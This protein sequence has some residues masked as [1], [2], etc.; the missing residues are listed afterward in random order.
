MK[1]K[2]INSPLSDDPLRFGFKMIFK[3]GES[4]IGNEKYEITMVIKKKIILKTL[5]KKIIKVE[6]IDIQVNKNHKEKVMI[7]IVLSHNSSEINIKI[8]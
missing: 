2:T 4:N 3:D 8:S 5:N 7:W 1:R 6:I